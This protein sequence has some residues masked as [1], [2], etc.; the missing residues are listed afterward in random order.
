MGPRLDPGLRLSRHPQHRRG[1]LPGANPALQAQA[2]PPA[3]PGS[4]A[5]GHPGENRIPRERARLRA[6]RRAAR[7]LRQHDCWT[8]GRHEIDVA[9]APR[10]DLGGNARARRRRDG[11]RANRHQGRARPAGPE[12]ASPGG[13]EVEGARGGA[14]QRPGAGAALPGH[15]AR[16][17]HADGRADPGRRAGSVDPA[18]RLGR[19]ARAERADPRPAVPVPQPRGALPGDRRPDRPRDPE[20]A[21]QGEH[22]GRHVLRERLQAVHRELPDP[23]AEGL[24]RAQ[25]PHHARAGDPGAVQGVRRDAGD[26]RLQ[27]ALQRAAAEGRRRPGEPDRHDRA[28]AL[29]RGAEVPHAV[30]PRVHRV[31]VHVQQAVP[32]QAARQRPHRSSST[33]RARRRRFQREIIVKTE[34]EHLETFRKAGIEII[35]LTPEQRARFEQASRPVYDWYTQ[36]YGSETLDIVR[37]D[38][39]ATTKK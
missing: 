17:R 36:K 35:K 26:G 25:D 28:D 4:A 1:P 2:R 31:R 37:K 29:L 11:G 5:A 13:A 30:R 8:G 15:D 14:H 27:G 38:I 33:R 23:R 10:G 20:A 3:L 12:H 7:A 19:A 9:S 34:A 21:Q 18:D 32:R 39:Q 22:R 6:S 16:Q 24:R